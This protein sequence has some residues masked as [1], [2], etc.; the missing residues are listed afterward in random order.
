MDKPEMTE[1][2]SQRAEVGDRRAIYMGAGAFVMGIPARDITVEEWD[3]MPPETQT[4]IAQ[5]GLYTIYP[6]FSKE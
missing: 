2:G 5:C 1:G 3:A 4:A 6:S